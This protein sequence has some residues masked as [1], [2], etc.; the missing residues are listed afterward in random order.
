MLRSMLRVAKRAAAC[1]VILVPKAASPFARSLGRTL[2]S[3]PHATGRR[4]AADLLRAARLPR[5]T[6]S[7]ACSGLRSF[8]AEK[9]KVVDR[10]DVDEVAAEGAAAAAA[11]DED[12]TAAAAEAGGADE[13]GGETPEVEALRAEVAEQAALAEEFKDKLMRTLAD[14]E[15]LRERTTRQAEAGPYP[16]HSTLVPVAAQPHLFV[17]SLEPQPPVCSP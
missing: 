4:S 11:T 6:A 17:T 7:F 3:A 5:Q 8:S 10:G 15:N 12:A 1:E 2:H 9:G 13:E 14:M 16:P